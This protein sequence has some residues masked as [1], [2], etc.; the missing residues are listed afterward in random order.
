MIIKLMYCHPRWNRKQKTQ[1]K[2]YNTSHKLHCNLMMTLCPCIHSVIPDDG[3][4]GAAQ[5]AVFSK[6]ATPVCYMMA[7]QVLL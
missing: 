3:V 6:T 7:T 4:P 1:T 2:H 5:M